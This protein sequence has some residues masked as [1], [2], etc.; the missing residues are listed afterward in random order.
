MS[1]LVLRDTRMTD[2]GLA[3]VATLT[4]LRRL[5]LTANEA[6]TDGCL[7]HL[8]GLDQLTELAIDVPKVTPEG[9]KRL[10]RKLPKLQVGR[11]PLSLIIVKQ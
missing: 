7:E 3:P 11:D 10:R 5:D 9:L 6:L 1:V 8:Y 4:N 2:P